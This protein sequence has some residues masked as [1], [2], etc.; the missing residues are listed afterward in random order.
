MQLRLRH[1]KKAGSLRI[2]LMLVGAVC[3]FSS[4]SK[5]QASV[6]NSNTIRI[7]EV[8]TLTGSEASFGTT[9][10]RGVELAI[11]K[12]NEEG[13]IHGKMLELVTLDDQGRAEET[14]TATTQLITQSHV[15]AVTGALP[16]SR[17]IAIAPIAQKFGIP[18]VSSASTHRDVTRAGNYIFRVCFID[19]FQ[20][21]VMAK[22]AL[23]HLKL[24]SVAILKDSKS[25]YSEGLAEYFAKTFQKGG[26]TISIQQ[27]YSSGDIDFKSQ[28]TAIRSKAPQAIFAPGYYTDIALAARQ[29]RELGLAVPL[30]GGDGWDSPQFLSIGG[31]AVNNAYYLTHYSAQ[32]QSPKVQ[33]FVSRF[34]K[35]FK[36]NP[37]GLAV[38]GYDAI[39]VLADAMKRAKSLSPVDIRQAL[40]ETQAF[41]G[42]T[43]KIR[44]DAHRNPIKSGVV[45]KIEQNQVKYLATIDP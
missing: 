24:K 23:D 42:V 29:A 15:I 19:P 36:M 17:G 13:G 3:T 22:F 33:E 21:H 18:L 37:D 41:V 20:G 4:C 26:G 12:I 45:L 44:F 16:S 30:L 39:D 27:S 14:A 2:F 34:K 28:L 40:E 10:H 9:S 38:L 6:E 43:G 11:Q 35:R 1:K 32:D 7:G 25:D 31:S 5:N 8:T